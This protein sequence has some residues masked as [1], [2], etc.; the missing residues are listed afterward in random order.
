MSND[1]LTRSYYEWRKSLEPSFSQPQL[2]AEIGV[3]KRTIE[4]WIAGSV[5]PSHFAQTEILR[6][7]QA[8][9]EFFQMK[10][11]R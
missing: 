2:A 6:R 9:E 1:N 4:R 11:P 10:M 5:R 3:S 8:S 7:V